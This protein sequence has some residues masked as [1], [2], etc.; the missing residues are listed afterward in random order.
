MD[1]ADGLEGAITYNADI[2][3]RE[4]GAA[5]KERYVELLQARGPRART[6]RWTRSGR[7]GESTSATYLHKL[8][9]GD[10]PVARAAAVAAATGRRQ[11]S[12]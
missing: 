1:K 9:A 3:R 4:T 10:A 8:A 12:R 7:S 11:A 6:T 5:F 2:Y